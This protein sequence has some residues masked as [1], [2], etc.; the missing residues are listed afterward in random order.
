LEHSDLLL[1]TAEVSIA[2]AG[3]ASLVTLLGRRGAGQNL[4][5][6]VARLR[7]MILISL[8]ALAFSLFPFLPYALGA[9]PQLVW[10]ISSGVFFLAAGG[11]LWMQLRHL[12][13]AGQSR[14]GSLY[15]NIPLGLLALGLLAV[16]SVVGLGKASPGIYVFCLFSALFVSGF[17]FS[18][19]FLSF[20]SGRDD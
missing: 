11:I 18:L 6:D 14:A 9:P 4:L 13:Q 15:V 5:L 17:L 19:A 12:K 10:R 1:T 8:L 16:N 20:L 2:F 3:F 7:G